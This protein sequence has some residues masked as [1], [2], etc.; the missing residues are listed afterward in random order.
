M[1]AA[2]LF[3]FALLAAIADLIAILT[4]LKIE[5]SQIFS[6]NWWS[7]REISITRGKLAGILGLATISLGLSSYGFYSINQAEVAQ[8]YMLGWGVD[9]V[10]T[11]PPSV[12]I[13]ANGHLLMK[14]RSSFKITGVC[15]IGFGT[16]DFLDDDL[17]KSGLHEITDDRIPI[18]IPLSQ[19]FLDR[20]RGYSGTNYELLLVPNGVTMDQFAT[21]RQ[22]QALGVR[23][24]QERHGPP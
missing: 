19:N 8:N 22:A 24:L 1:G 12:A 7:V 17:E 18:R 23:V 14:Y 2:A 16:H 3:V 20:H 11:N 10:V 15:F 6:R 9:G 21:T 5:P 13:V 4:W